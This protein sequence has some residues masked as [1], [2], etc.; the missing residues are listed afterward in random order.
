METKK[1]FGAVIWAFIAA[2]ALIV[3]LVADSLGILDFLRNW[4]IECRG[5]VTPPIHILCTH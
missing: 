1:S 2:L 4:G 5:G 3:G